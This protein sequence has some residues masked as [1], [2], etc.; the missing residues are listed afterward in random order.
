M[1]KSNQMVHI[2]GLMSDPIVIVDTE[3]IVLFANPAADRLLARYGQTITGEKFNLPFEIDKVITIKLPGT[4]PLRP[5]AAFKMNVERSTWDDKPAFVVLLEEAGEPDQI[6]EAYAESQRQFTTLTRNLPGMV[7]RCKYKEN[8]PMEYVSPN[9]VE[10]TGYEPEDLVD[11]KVIQYGDLIIIEDQKRVW[12]DV[13]TGVEQKRTFQLIYRIRT[14]SGNIKWV[15]EQGQGVFNQQGKLVALEGF[16][17]DITPQRETEEAL[18]ESETLFKTVFSHAGIGMALVDNDEHILE[19]NLALQRLVGYTE[20]ELR[21]MTILEITHPED[22]QTA[23]I[24]KKEPVETNPA[25]LEQCEKRYLRKEGQVVWVTQTATMIRDETGAVLYGLRMVE[26]ITSRKVNELVQKTIFDISQSAF[27]SSSLPDLFENIHTILGKMMSVDN[28]FI[29]LFDKETNIL[30]FPYFIDQYDDAPLP[31]APGRGL[32]E[33]VLRTGTPLL[34]SPDTFHELNLSGEVESIGAPSIDWLGVPLKRGDETIGVMVVQSY[35]ENIRF[36]PKELQLMTFVS[37]QVAM[38]VDRKR[39]EDMLRS[40][41]ARYRALVEATKDAIFVETIEGKILDV[42]EVA[43]NMLGYTREELLNSSVIDLLPQ[44]I[45][46]NVPDLIDQ[47]LKQGGLI[48]ESWNRRKDGSVFPVEVSTRISTLG[49]RRLVIAYIRDITERKKA[50]AALRESESKFRILAESTLTM[51]GIHRG[52]KFLYVNP[53]YSKALG[54]TTDEL[55]GMAFFDNAPEDLKAEFQQRASLCLTGEAPSSRYETRLITHDGQEVWVDC[56]TILVVFDGAPAV[57]FTM[58]DITERKR[59]EESLRLQFTALESAA[60]AIAITDIKGNISWCNRAFCELTGYQS[61]EVAQQ[62]IAILDSGIQDKEFFDRLWETILS[63]QTW[64]GELVNKRKDGSFYTEEM[65]ITP[66][67]NSMGQ[68]TNFVCIK[69]DVTE[70]L[71]RQRELEAIAGLSAALRTAITRVDILPVVLDQVTSLLSSNGAMLAWRDPITAETVL[72]ACSGVWEVITGRRLPL[73]VGISGRVINTGQPYVTNNIKGDPRFAFPDLAT[74]MQAVAAVPLIVQGQTL[75]ALMVGGRSVITEDDL[76]VLTAISDIAASAIHRA[77][78]IE[79]TR[80]Q[81]HELSLAYDATIEGWARALELRD[82]ETQGHTRRVTNFTVRLAQAVGMI[83]TELEHVRRGVLLHDIGKMGVPDTIL[84]KNGELTREEW[85]V[86]RRH[87][88][89]AYEM[90]SPI[91]YLRPALDI[92]Y[93]HHER[94]DGEGYPRGLKEDQIPLPARIFA[95]VDVWDALTSDRPYRPAWSRK[96]ALAF[97]RKQSGHQFD[98][99]VVA[100]FLELVERGD[101]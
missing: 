93:C 43:Q 40:E 96:A 39:A 62:N 35:D 28:F 65:T 56:S 26:D 13:K 50:E 21:G 91:A 92:P 51:I 27:A 54:Y 7:Y 73:G 74:Q 95:V 44:E 42:N 17:N 37:T 12:N 6:Q 33:Y 67:T 47:Q 8:W 59:T 58:I 79:Q 83:G 68:I 87:P 89:Y 34:A 78:L 2:L 46:A 11:G 45:A 90:L 5:N 61:D 64:H 14:K 57:M 60:N 101:I 24:G 32:T 41:E 98:P 81:A 16:I 100:V 30:T 36:S 49:D 88:E 23:R 55:M 22:R 77:E 31:K 29:A 75:G 25:G 1:P 99:K 76:R 3:S 84:L 97:I 9:C 18:R 66:V 52:D 72:Q 48:L 69:L 53:A 10:L 71:Q 20:D 38:A 82:K 94:W 86:M 19:S 80:S 85:T 63:N 4:N 70:R 15:W